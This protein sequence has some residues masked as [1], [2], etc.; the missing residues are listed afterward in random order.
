MNFIF[1]LEDW[2]KTN[3]RLQT[4]KMGQL[5]LDQARS[6]LLSPSLWYLSSSVLSVSW[7]G[8]PCQEFLLQHDRAT[9]AWRQQASYPAV[10]W[11]DLIFP[12]SQ[13]SLVL[14]CIAP[15]LDWDTLRRRH[16]PLLSR[17]DC[18]EPAW[19]S[20]LSQLNEVSRIEDN[21]GS[22]SSLSCSFKLIL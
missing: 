7:W 9:P 15:S 20:I 18:L 12:A 16:L 2:Y 8:L 1:W 21:L 6:R 5:P 22:T 10:N 3:N 17:S 14:T 11:S 13:L 19:E 4:L